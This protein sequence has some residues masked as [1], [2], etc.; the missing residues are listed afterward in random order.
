MPI[1]V[2]VSIGELLD[3]I[4]ILDIKAARIG[5]P[6]KLENV[7]RERQ[8]LGEAAAGLDVTAEPC[9]ALM[10]ELRTVNEALWQVE[11]DLRD[12]ERNGDFGPRFVELARAVYHTNDRRA[13]IK[14]A[15]NEAF[16]SDL[17][18]EKSYRSY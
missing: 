4:V 5:D 8:A 6:A 12:C 2:P 18:E 3:K 9:A 1:L 17:V 14:R 11:D 10:S 15:L 13:A 16:G 7:R